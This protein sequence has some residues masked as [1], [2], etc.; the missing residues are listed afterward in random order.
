MRG[1]SLPI[2]LLALLYGGW[3]IWM[4]TRP[5]PPSVR[6]ELFQGITYIRDARRSPR[7]LV[8]HVVRVQLDAPGIGFVATPGD[9][10]QRLPL[11][12]RLTS[13]FLTEFGAQVAINADFFYPWYSHNIFSYYPHVGDPVAA[14]GIGITDGS[15][16]HAPGPE[17]APYP[18]LYFSGGNRVRFHTPDGPV[19]N[20]ISGNRM[21]VREGA[22]V[23][24]NPR[25]ADKLDPRTAIGLDKT[26]RVL[27]IV[28]IDGRQPNYSEGAT[29][30]ETGEILRQYG[31]W[32]GMNLD[33]GGS[34]TLAV[35][36]T[37][38]EDNRA[39]ANATN[40]KTRGKPPRV[41]IL[42][43]PIDNYIPNRERPVANHLGI[44]ARHR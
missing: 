12:A 1:I 34:S 39:R 26:R 4:R 37:S 42:N 6:R 25:Y 38:N 11:R 17:T 5:Q 41:E 31:A 8:A 13:A 21:L 27:I 2:L 29:Q 22:I 36:D 15:A 40:N 19:Q 7:P 3:Q 23:P 32:E 24:G 30:T 33:G 16:Y 43:C 44:F 18:T 14:Q 28:L 10:K 20:A 9:P 35:E